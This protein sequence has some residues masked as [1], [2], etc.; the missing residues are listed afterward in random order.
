MSFRHSAIVAFLL[1]F[2]AA[3]ASAQT[4]STG[5]EAPEFI[6]GDVNGQNG[7]GHISNSPTR[8]DIEAAPVGS[9]VSFGAQSLALRTRNVDFFGVA[10]HLYSATVNPAAGETGS[11]AGGVVVPN[12]HSHFSASLWY[13]TPTAPVIS[14]RGDGRFAQLNPSSKGSGAADPANRYAQVR[15]YNT[16][17][18][19]AGLVRVEIGWYTSTGFVVAAV[20][21]NLAWGE[22]YRFEYLIH[23]ANGLNGLEPNDR[24]TLTI[25]D[26]NGTRLGSA[27][28]STWELAWKSGSF[29]GGTSPRAING[30]DLWSDSGPNALL[31]GHLDQYTMTTFT[32]AEAFAVSI[33]GSAN[34]CPATTTTLSANTTGGTATTY[35]WRDAANTI[36]ATTPTYA[37]LPGTYTVTVTD[38]LCAPATSAPFTVTAYPPLAV[39][40]SGATSVPMNAQTT[41]TANPTGGTGTITSYTWRNAANAIVGTAATLNAGIGTYTV[42]VTDPCGTAT[43]APFTI[44]AADTATIPTASEWGLLVML[45]ALGIVAVRR[46]S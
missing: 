10:N 21:T 11:T 29:G 14:T 4:L 30:F 28:G 25:F 19:A 27:C 6:L 41:L 34:T 37:A 40:I 43:S 9:P 20:A 31:V 36:V 7:W 12:P 45:S 2:L 16:T 44:A 5:F 46:L 32:P 35:T 8:G 33:T 1:L 17:N 13:R 26:R 18:T 3:S 15:I 22:W 23:L 42:T 39:T 38:A 24:F